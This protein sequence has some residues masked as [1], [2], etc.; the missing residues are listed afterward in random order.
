MDQVFLYSISCAPP[1][2][3]ENPAPLE[4][5]ASSEEEALSIAHEDGVEREWVK[6]VACKNPW[7]VLVGKTIKA[8]TQLKK[9]E[10]DDTGYLRVEMTDG[11]TYLIEG[12]CGDQCTMDS[13]GEY[14]TFIALKP[15]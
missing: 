15:L 11:S 4:C 2:G 7:D 3:D 6:S 9:P 5:E 8:V 12:G 10:Y 14:P 1:D 13:E